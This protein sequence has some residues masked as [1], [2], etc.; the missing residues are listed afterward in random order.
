[1]TTTAA[2]RGSR[3]A[4]RRAEAATAP[5]SELPAE[6]ALAGVSLATVAAF[7]RL[8]EGRGWFAPL[9]AVALLAHVGLG[10][11]RRRGW[12][13]PITAVATMVGFVLATTVLFFLDSSYLGLPGP[14]TLDALGASLDEAVSLFAEVVAPAPAVT[15]FL[16][17]AA[18]GIVVAAFLADWAAFRLWSPI[19]AVVP[20][21]TLFLFTALLGV[22]GGA[23]AAS[24]LFAGA[25]VVFLVLH[26]GVRLARTGT[27]VGDQRAHGRE[28]VVKT[29]GVLGL[30]A[31]LLGAIA[32]PRLPGADA[33]P[34]IEWRNES[35]GE[36]SRVTISPLVDIQSRL[37]DQSMTEV[38]TVR[39]SE[40]AY[41][42]LTALDVFDGQIW[43]SGGRYRPADGELPASL[44]NAAEHRRVEQRFTISALAALWLPAAFE[45]T[46]VRS[47]ELD[48]RYQP[49]SQT[50]IVDTD[51]ES[52]DGAEYLVTSAIPSFSPETL[53]AAPDTDDADLVDRFTELP[54]N[55]SPTATQT[56]RDV[57]AGRASAYDQARAL[58]DWFR[59]GGGFTYSLE[60][61][62]GH[63][64]SAIDAF[65]ESRVGYCEQFAGTFAAMARS[66]GI[67]ARVAVG[68]TPGEADAADPELYRVR[69]EHA[70]AWPEVYFEGLG[71]VPFEPTPGRGAPG[72]EAWTGLAEDQAPDDGVA[73][74]TTSTATG[75][76][77][78]T[79]PDPSPATTI[80]P[81]D[82][83]D[84]F[85]AEGDRS[86]SGSDGSG[87]GD[88]GLPAPLRWAAVVLVLAVVY[89][90]A[91]P[92][93]RSARRRA[94]RR[95]AGDDTGS[96]V[97]L[98]W[99]ESLEDLA[100]LGTV[101]GRAETFDEFADRAGRRLPNHADDLRT[102]AGAVTEA[103]Y[104]PV[105][106]TPDTATRAETAA[107]AIATTVRNRLSRADRVRRALDPRPLLRRR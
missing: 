89:G 58:Q 85:T 34:L 18:L 82:L 65:L 56:A 16:L 48:V 45:P 79:V 87:R 62:R 60:V 63:D 96:R 51:I 39:S 12:S 1:M 59:T 84:V 49:E 64:L 25:V 44:A 20:A 69:G 47:A 40:P 14:A 98:A 77:A 106:V 50:L 70:H 92:A 11:C 36:G 24:A 42:R 27:W 33:D 74:T 31:V 81:S 15:G 2:P 7:G 94:R 105:A 3:L 103:D 22:S 104:A 54:D 52:S 9:A 32:G 102:I 35:D 80:A 4:A 78:G 23:V 67:P 38:F 73:P 46:E 97:R 13:I 99:D 91:V 30:T 57:T 76:T 93:L 107:V 37:V 6:M 86:G 90:L 41:W 66:L 5:G 17:S 55:F 29:G 88:D 28:W 75:D 10:L 71:W 100:A 61:P 8:F 26:R 95:R 21:A 83:D 53:R 68:F 101:R 19:E 43:R 72:A